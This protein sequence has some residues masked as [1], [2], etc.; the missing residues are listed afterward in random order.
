[1]TLTESMKVSAC[2][3]ASPNQVPPEVF[4]GLALVVLE[5]KANIQ[6]TFP[7]AFPVAGYGLL[8]STGSSAA[9]CADPATVQ[10]QSYEMEYVGRG[11][12]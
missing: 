7:E 4:Q 1:M 10:C 6:K 11:T 12:N 2:S 8:K 9:K 5:V 3:D